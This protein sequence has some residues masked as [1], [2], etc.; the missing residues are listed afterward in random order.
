MDRRSG[1]QA[2]NAAAT[3]L[4]AWLLAGT[5]DILAAVTYYP[6]TVHVTPTRILQGIASGV[7]G[8]Q[9]SAGGLAAAA[10]G[11]ALHYLIALIWTVVFFVAFRRLGFLAKNL[12]VTGLGYGVFVGLVM[13]LVVLPLSRVRQGP[14]NLAHL[15][16]AIVILLFT[17]GL[18]IAG[19]V[20][21]YYAARRPVRS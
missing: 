16:V 15:I 4:S 6:L 13:N 5:L 10:L 3:I 21:W 7:L 9:A 20:G 11:L 18:P 8:P 17:V 14:F 19:I 1:P 2:P 12:V